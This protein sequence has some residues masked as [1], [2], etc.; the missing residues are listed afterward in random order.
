MTHRISHGLAVLIF[1]FCLMVCLDAGAQHGPGHVNSISGNGTSRSISTIWN[2]DGTYSI[3][4]SYMNGRTGERVSRLYTSW[5]NQ[6]TDYSKPRKRNGR[7][8][9]NAP[10]YRTSSPLKIEPIKAKVPWIKNQFYRED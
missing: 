1:L 7:A 9:S 10:G 6:W 4:E 3:S 5:D 8:R 2:K